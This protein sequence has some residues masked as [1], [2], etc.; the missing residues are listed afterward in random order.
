MDVTPAGDDLSFAYV[1]GE[2]QGGETVDCGVQRGY[3]KPAKPTKPAF[4]HEALYLEM[5]KRDVR[6]PGSQ[7]SMEAEPPQLHGILLAPAL[8]L[9]AP[10]VKKM[11]KR[12]EVKRMPTLKGSL[13]LS[14]AKAKGV[15]RRCRGT[16][17]SG[18][19]AAR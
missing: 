13:L 12:P 8:S 15:V 5:E 9:T 11:P 2:R 18:S 17:G 1:V 3:G 7:S 16:G 14:M 10:K 6:S 19:A 4:F